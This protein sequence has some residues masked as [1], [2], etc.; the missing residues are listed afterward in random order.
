MAANKSNILVV[1]DDK[2]I[3]QL[4]K[5]II[6]EEYSLIVAED[7]EKG[8]AILKENSIDLLITDL[9]LPGMSGIEVVKRAM[10]INP[11]MASIVM[12]GYATIETA[13]EAMKLGAYNYIAKP[14][15]TDAFLINVRRALEYSSLKKENLNL[16]ETLEK[17]YSFDSII[18]VSSAIQTVRDA[19]RI[20][21]DS[22]STILLL[23]ETGTGKELIAKIIHCNSSRR[24]FPFIPVNCGGIPGELLESELFGHE[25]GAFTGAITTRLGRFERA[26]KGT[27]FLDEIGDMPLHLQVKLLRVIQ[28]REFERVGGNK[29]IQADVGI[30]AATNR[31]LEDAI[32]KKLFRKDLYYRLNVIPIVIPPLRERKEDIPLLL[33]HF[34]NIISHRKKRHIAGISDKAMEVLINY[35]WHGN[36][37]ELEN[38]VERIVILKQD[39]DVIMPQDIPPQ[40]RMIK[41]RAALSFEIPDNGVNLPA[42]VET[43]EN[44]L[45][46]KALNRAGGVKSKAAELL[47]INRTT[48]IEKMKKKGLLKPPLTQPSPLRGED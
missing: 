11:D 7:G 26:N 14:F 32:E 34:L 35:Q 40:I 31:D 13:V 23:G 1:E 37:R 16:R 15:K 29:T 41:E 3:R 27:I 30:I 38:M 42:M 20:V 24:R 10:E 18:G 19:I 47:S 39:S 5:D 2:S 9:K 17:R 25:K 12:T 33:R 6:G 36:I 8:V 44:G 28:E 43:L 21:A 4:L 22:D 45:I 46:E 48:L